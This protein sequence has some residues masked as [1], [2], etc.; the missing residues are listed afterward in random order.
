MLIFTSPKLI[1]R[2]KLFQNLYSKVKIGIH[3]VALLY[4]QNR[5]SQ[6]SVFSIIY[7]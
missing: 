2:K 6:T 5:I 3:K 4:N 1:E 7:L